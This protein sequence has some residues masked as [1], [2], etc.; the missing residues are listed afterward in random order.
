MGNVSGA[1]LLQVTWEHMTLLSAHALAILRDSL[2]K[3]LGQHWRWTHPVRETQDHFLLPLVSSYLL[4]IDHSLRLCPL[5]GRS[6]RPA[7]GALGFLGRQTLFQDSAQANMTG[8]GACCAFSKHACAR[9]LLQNVPALL[10]IVIA[11]A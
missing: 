9:P 2:L 4:S 7:A 3:C 8:T 11:H 10:T 6:C 5:G 1:N